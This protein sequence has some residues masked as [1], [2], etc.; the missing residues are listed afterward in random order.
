LIPD[1]DKMSKRTTPGGD[2]AALN[3]LVNRL[4][5]KIDPLSPGSVR[6]IAIEEAGLDGLEVQRLLEANGVES[7]STRPLPLATNRRQT[8]ARRALP[9]R[10]A[11]SNTDGE[12]RCTRAGNGRS[13][14]CL[15]CSAEP[16]H[17]PDGQKL[18]PVA[19]SAGESGEDK[20]PDCG[21]RNGGT[22]HT[23]C[24]QEGCPRCRS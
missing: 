21:V 11:E 9:D 15:T 23:G 17:F 3:E 8:G 5:A 16:I 24:D 6:V 14:S 1:G 2:G 12:V 22:H 20:R 18:A 19:Y 7:H 10:P 4:R 13:G